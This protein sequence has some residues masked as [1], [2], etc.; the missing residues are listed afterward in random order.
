MFIKKYT[1][2]NQ[3]MCKAAEDELC[4]GLEISL[5]SIRK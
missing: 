4:V 1:F 3:K 5:K 2:Y